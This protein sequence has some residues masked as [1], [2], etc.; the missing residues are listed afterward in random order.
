MLEANIASQ[1]DVDEN[2]NQFCSYFCFISP[3]AVILHFKDGIKSIAPT[4][5][6]K[7]CCF[8]KF[9][10][11]REEQYTLNQLRGVLKYIRS[12]EGSTDFECEEDAILE[13]ELFLV[14][15]ENSESAIKV[16]FLQFCAVV[17]RIPILGFT[18]S[19]EVFFT[20]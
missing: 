9:F 6:E 11:K 16:G 1:I 7:P 20:R 4:I 3:V 14:S 13:V 15:L 2:I 8:K 19:I 12:V 17:D 5:L 18:K 10:V